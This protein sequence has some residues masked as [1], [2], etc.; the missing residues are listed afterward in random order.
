M[1]V[2]LGTVFIA[3]LLGSLHCVGMCG[4][5]ALL[6][7][8]NPE[9]KS[10]AVGPTMA[11]SFGRL[12]TYSI[13]GLIFGALGMAINQGSAFNHWQQTATYVAGGLMIVVGLVA[14]VRYFGVRV[15]LPTIATP[16]QRWLQSAFQ[17]TIQMQPLPRAITIGMLT[18]LMPC[19][20]LYTF[21]ITAAGT[22]SPL[23][24][25]ILMMVFWAGT[26][27]IMTA[28]MLGVNRIS[29]RV[30]AKIP[31]MMAVLVVVLGV[32]TIAFRAPIDLSGMNGTV[33]ADAS[34]E[35][36]TQQI[37][38]VDHAELPCCACEKE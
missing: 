28:L 5:F 33:A 15:K 10:A 7:S 22:G 24:G 38:E 30:Q 31:L 2:L 17:R 27:P 12:I 19:G 26:V 34:S 6:A 8:T 25:M 9:A 32:F 23:T 13:I 18:S 11:Y 35:T 37:T 16:L 4:P 1:F 21:G 36:L 29:H 14:L 20:W 3:S